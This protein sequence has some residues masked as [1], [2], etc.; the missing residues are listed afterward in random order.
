MNTLVLERFA[1]SP[2]GTFGKLT[3]PEGE[4]FYTAECPWFGNATGTSCIP[5]GIYSLGKRYSPTVKRTS[6]NQFSEGWEVLDVPERS[7]I[8]IHPA[9]FPLLDLE[10]CIAIGEN[11]QIIPDR[12]GV[13]RNAVIKSRPAFKRFMELLETSDYWDLHIF[14]KRIEYP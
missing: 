3:F 2:D 1:Y 8:M 12:M 13:A 11:Y 4:E 7:F 6:A 9:N 14:Q 10:G 5:E